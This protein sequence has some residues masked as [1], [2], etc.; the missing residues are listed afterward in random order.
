MALFLVFFFFFFG[1]YDFL[2]FIIAAARTYPV[3]QLG[4]VAIRAE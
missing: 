4:L 1:L 3:G 2:A